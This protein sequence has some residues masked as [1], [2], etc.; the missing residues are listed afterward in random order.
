[1][2]FSTS[3][4]EKKIILWDERTGGIVF[5]Y[6][7]E[8]IKTFIPQGKIL[9]LGPYSE[10]I[11]ATQENKSMFFVWKT[12]TVDA[13]FKSSPIEEKITVYKTTNDCLYLY[14]GTDSG[15]VYLYE[16]FSGNVVASFQSHSEKVNDLEVNSEGSTV[17]TCSHDCLVRL[18]MLEK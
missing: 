13:I 7:D 2:I 11:I 9:L 1:M 15:K 14:V 6:E 4:D 3:R 18:F 8:S 17:V 12:D 10:Y 5:S 16:L